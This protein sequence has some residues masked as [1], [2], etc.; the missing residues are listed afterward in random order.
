MP[1][2]V[3]TSTSN[4]FSIVSDYNCKTAPEQISACDPCFPMKPQ[5]H[6]KAR[7]TKLL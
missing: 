4:Y 7:L 3:G 1:F 6:E 2:D 5:F